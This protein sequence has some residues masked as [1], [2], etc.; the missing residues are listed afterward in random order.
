MVTCK[1][2]RIDSGE[3]SRVDCKLSNPMTFNELRPLRQHNR[4]M[5]PTSL[6][7]T[8]CLTI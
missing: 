3:T 8:K 2:L 5:L 1:R 4:K 7:T 6:R